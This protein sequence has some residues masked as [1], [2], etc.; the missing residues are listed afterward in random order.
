MSSAQQTPQT[1]V[2][3]VSAS[4]PATHARNTQKTA[5]STQLDA[6][7]PPSTHLSSGSLTDRT[8]VT[9]VVSWD[10]YEREI[11]R[12]AAQLRSKREAIRS[13]ERDADAVKRGYYVDPAVLAAHPDVPSLQKECQRIEVGNCASRTCCTA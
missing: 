8:K 7:A 5:Q 2:A 6:K 9:P 12:L 4:G 1:F 11:V 10:R 13:A 3:G